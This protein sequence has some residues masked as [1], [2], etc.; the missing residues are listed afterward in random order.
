MIVAVRIVR[1]VK[2]PLD[3]VI[4]VA[5][6]RH[7]FVA[8]PGAMSV[9]AF[10]AAAS[11]RFRAILRIGTRGFDRVLVYVPLVH[12]VQMAVMQIVDV[13]GMLDFRVRAIGTM[14]V[15][16]LVMRSMFHA[17]SVRYDPSASQIRKPFAFGCLGAPRRAL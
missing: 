6:M 3:E 4:R 13:S 14:L 16:M 11:V 5:G 12:V 2:V 7:S 1:V 10:V 8:A 15:R 17:D 9:A